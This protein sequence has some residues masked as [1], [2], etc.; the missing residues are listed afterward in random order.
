MHARY[1]APETSDRGHVGPDSDRF[2]RGVVILQVG[3][4]KDV[5]MYAILLGS[6]THIYTQSSSHDNDTFNPHPH[7]YAH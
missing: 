5:H 7:P 2:A 3:T 1:I 6:S 4:H